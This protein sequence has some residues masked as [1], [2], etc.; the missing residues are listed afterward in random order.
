MTLRRFLLGLG[1]AGALLATPTAAVAAPTC[2]DTLPIAN[3]GQHVVGDYVTGMGHDALEWPPAGQ[4]GDAT[5]GNRGAVLPG[6]PG[7]SFHFEN[8]FAPGASFC[9]G[10]NSP[11]LHP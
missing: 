6:G 11:G 2:A 1:L 10:S 8:G 5:G 9:T 4:V 7:P 3:H